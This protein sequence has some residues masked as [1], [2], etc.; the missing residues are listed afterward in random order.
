[1]NKYTLA[2]YF[3]IL[4]ALCTAVIV[5]AKMLGQQGT[6][7]AQLYMLTP[8]IAAII[9]RLFFYRPRFS[10]ANLRFGKP[11]DYFIFWL[12]SICI[13]GL[14]YVLL[15]LLGSITWDFTG[16]AFLNR[17]AEQFAAADQDINASL[18]PGLTPRMMLMVYF[19]GGLTVFNI[20][21]GIITGFGEEFGHRGFMFPHLYKIKPWIGIVLGGLI[22]Y[23]WHWPLALVIPQTTQ[24]PLWQYLLNFVTLAIGSVCTFTYLAYVY[25]KSRSVWVTSLAHIAMNNS[26]SAFSY[27]AIIQDQVLANIGLALTMMIV[28]IV[29]YFK[30]ELTTFQGYFQDNIAG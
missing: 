21:P 26:A 29:L 23:A 30:K 25:V 4:L 9:T 13:T 14:S 7:L 12:V 18:P 24:Y 28:V 10:D 17:L 11:S 2:I 27:F 16:Q 6:Y 22:W 3:I 20:L 19:A 15:T 1:M 5:G 8:A